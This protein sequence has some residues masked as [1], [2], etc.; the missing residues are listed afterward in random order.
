MEA[1]S[2]SAEQAMTVAPETEQVSSSAGP[3]WRALPIAAQLYVSVVIL[4]GIGGLWAFLPTN[5]S[6][7]VVFGVLIAVACVTSTWKVNL[8]LPLANGA[9]PSVSYAA[10]FV[11]LVV[12][13]P[14]G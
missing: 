12:L 10:D 11:T 13:V 14:A 7:P 2:R 4:A 3:R 5:V 1:W 6:S 9:S 8:P